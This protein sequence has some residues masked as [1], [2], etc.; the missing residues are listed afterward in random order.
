[1]LLVDDDEVNRRISSKF[2]QV[3]GCTTDAAVNGIQAVNRMDSKKYDLARFV[4]F[5]NYLLFMSLGQDNVI[6]KLDG[7]TAT[8]MIRQFD[9]ITPIIPM[10]SSSRPNE[11]MTYY[12]HG[13][14]SRAN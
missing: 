13:K 14:L 11:I 12:S 2:L 5:G 3:F 8:S 7:V 6:P 9:Y 4:C 1:M 10:T